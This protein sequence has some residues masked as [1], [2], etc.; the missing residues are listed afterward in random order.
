MKKLIALI[1]TMVT[2]LSFTSVVSVSAASWPSLSS[3][4]YCEFTA[5]KQIN[6][7]K[8]TACKTR[9]TS[10]P[11]K[12]YDAYI[13]KNDVCYIYKITTS[14]AQVNYPTSSGRRTGYIKRSDLIG[15]SSP[16]EKITS[17]SKAA[18]YVSPKGASYGYIEKGDNVYTCGT[19]SASD[20]TAVIYTAKS[21][22]RAYKYGWVTTSDYNSKIKETKSIP[23]PQPATKSLADVALSEVGYQGTDKTGNDHGDYTKYGQW[24]GQNGVQWCAEFVSWCVNKAGVST[25]IVPKT[26]SCDTMK[27]NSNSYKT[28]SNSALKNIKKNDVIFFAN[29]QNA[30]H[31]D[32]VGIVYNISGSNI[33]VIE[34]NTGNYYGPDTVAKITYT[35]DSAT[36]KITKGYNGKYFCGYISVN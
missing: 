33:T 9:G 10:S 8:D 24:Y 28:W 18:T 3:S 35:V 2:V 1:L 16:T 31:S 11:A 20:Y 6:V 29:S 12:A 19:S 36:G 7:Y 23:T 13:S 22:N 27:K 17:K 14:Y 5:A 4:A 30:S 15:V 25:K 34:G 26:A 32:H 21:G